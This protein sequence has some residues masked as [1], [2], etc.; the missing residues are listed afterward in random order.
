MIN[1]NQITSQLA[2]M[3][4]Q[5]LQRYAQMHKADPYILSLALAES[6]RRKQMRQ[7]AQ[8]S[9]PEQPKVVDQA[10]AGIAQLPAQNLQGMEQTMAAGGIVAFD[11]G[12]EVERYNGEAGSLIPYG[13]AYGG[14]PITGRTGYEG[15]SPMELARALYEDMMQKIGP[16]LSPPE[17]AKAERAAR[18][19]ANKLAVAKTSQGK[20]YTPEAY[21]VTTPAPLFPG[22][23]GP[24]PAEI[25]TPAPS[26]RAAAPRMAPATAPAAGPELLGGPGPGAA[27]PAA[28]L[29]GLAT[30]PSTLRAEFEQFA[31][32]GPVKDPFEADIRRVGRMDVDAAKAA[33]AERKQQISEMGLFGAEQER[34]LKEREGRLAGQEAQAAPMALLQAG[35]AMMSGSSPYA[36][37][38][39]GLGAQVGLK[40][41]SAGIDKL[42]AAR[43]KLE[44]AYGRIET[45]R[46]SEKMLTDREM[47]ELAKGVRQAESQVEK[48]V[49]AG[50]RQAYGLARA[51]AKTLFD[52]YKD[53]MRANAELG[54]RER[55]GLAQI[56]SQERI[57]DLNRQ[58]RA[59]EAKLLAGRGELKSDAEL[60]EIYAKSILL[61]QRFPN[62]EDYI[63]MVKGTG[64]AAG[65]DYSKWGDPVKVGP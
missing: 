19:E 22:A 2:K 16:G 28:G 39:M 1:V 34:R 31:P 3:P 61:Q 36:L 46:R 26:D 43:E 12:G 25:S 50:A 41:Y 54:Q 60:R 5:T 38:N 8:M 47:A 30:T 14:A 52:A 27:Q 56:Q 63:K 32:Q 58:A 51:D 29:P 40:S 21:G 20:T 37:Q 9:V 18:A 6:N 7:G 13:G 35:L 44:D 57:A 64:G 24:G 23:R 45:A 10:I 17:R 49:V 48:D 4:D 11:E 55:L 15:M 53:N 65:I 33:Q 59:Q 42:E 62:V